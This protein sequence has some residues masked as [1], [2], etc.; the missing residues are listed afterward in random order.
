M[1]GGDAG[2]GAGGGVTWSRGGGVTDEGVEGRGA[3][4]WVGVTGGMV[5]RGGDARGAGGGDAGDV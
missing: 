4:G 1:S 5:G 2:N 3:A